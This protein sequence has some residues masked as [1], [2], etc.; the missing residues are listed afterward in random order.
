[1]KKNLLPLLLLF[2]LS[3][4]GQWSG[5]VIDTLTQNTERDEILHQSFV[6]DQ[7]N[8]LHLISERALTA[9]GWMILYFK[10][11]ANSPWTMEDTVSIGPSYGMIGVALEVSRE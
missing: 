10:H 11:P 4:F 3:A 6:S 9:G 1:M 8:T 5:A 7:G 2:S